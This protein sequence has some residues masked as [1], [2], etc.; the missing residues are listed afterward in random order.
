MTT[1]DQNNLAGLKNQPILSAPSG[2][3]CIPNIS[4]AERRGRLFFGLLALA[5]GIVLLAILMATGAT[6]WLRLLLFLPFAGA[7][8]GYFQWADKTCVGLAR[9][10]SRHIGDQAE[11][12]EDAGEL[13]QIKFQASR[14]QRKAML[15]AI[16][17]TLIALLLPVLA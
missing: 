3:V 1:V 4:T 14:V 13:A 11:K 2:D 10:N 5:V 17:L 15:A 12:I 8:S 16:P 7:T 9:V 6:R